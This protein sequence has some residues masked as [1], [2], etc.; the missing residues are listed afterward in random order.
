M[1]LRD[2]LLTEVF[3]VQDWMYKFF[4]FSIQWFRLRLSKSTF[5][6]ILYFIFILWFNFL[7]RNIYSTKTGMGSTSSFH[8]SQHCRFLIL[9]LS[10]IPSSITLWATIFVF[11]WFPFKE[12]WGKVK[13]LKQFWIN[14]LRTFGFEFFRFG[15]TRLGGLRIVELE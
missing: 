8:F 15:E 12:S 1:I 3:M 11:C 2:F 4:Y 6:N 14:F 9:H 5:F 7:F 10:N 13:S